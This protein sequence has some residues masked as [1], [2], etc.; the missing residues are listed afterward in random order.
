MQESSLGKT[1]GRNHAIAVGLALF[2]TVLWSSSWVLIKIGLS[3]VPALTFAGLRY[4]VAFVLLLP[5]LALRENRAH[6]SAMTRMDW[7]SLALLGLVF[8]TLTQGAQFL[9]L[10]YLPAQTASLFLSFSPVLVALA[11]ALLIGERPSLL[12]IAGVLIYVAGAATFLLPID[13][14]ESRTI[15]YVIA[16]VGVASNAAAAILGRYVNRKAHLGAVTVTTVSMGIGGISLL[17]IGVV[18]QGMPPLEVRSIAIVGWLALVNTALAFTIWNRTLRHLS[19]LESSII[20]STMLIQI[21]I[22]AWIF[23]DESLGARQ[24]IGLAVAAG[25]GLLSQITAPARS[26]ADKVR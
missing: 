3:D 16:A 23:L 26:R 17:C 15:G 6:F 22:L 19:A 25:G 13:A 2:V 12:Q 7:L 11:S 9:A 24:M 10:V 5:L 1:G 18:S 20:N 14:G 8:Y 21:A 4:S